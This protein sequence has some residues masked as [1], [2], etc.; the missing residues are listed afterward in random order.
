MS[1]LTPMLPM[2]RTVQNEVLLTAGACTELLARRDACAAL[3]AATHTGLASLYLHIQLACALVRLGRLDTARQEL[4]TA[5]SLAAPDGLCFPFAE[6]AADLT[7]LLPELLAAMPAAEAMLQL[8]AQESS[9][10]LSPRELEIAHLAAQRR[11]N[12]EIAAA[13]HLSESTVKNHLKRIFD[14]LGLDGSARG[15]RLL[16]GELLP[17]NSP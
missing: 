1:F 7:P 2:L 15:K 16:L 3:Y 14:K 8:T 12:A 13:L 6:H 5:I 17:K 11:T 4:M 10:G 9:Y